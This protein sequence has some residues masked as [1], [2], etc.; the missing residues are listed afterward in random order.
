MSD[1]VR[2]GNNDGRPM[3]ERAMTD[4]LRR[5]PEKRRLMLTQVLN[6]PVLNPAGDELGRLEDLIVKLGEGEYPPV[7][8]IKV[9]IGGRDVYVGIKDVEKLAPGEVRLSNNTLNTGAFQ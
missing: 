3:H 2:N 8:G 7:T 4:D 5:R 6:S 9:R 1:N